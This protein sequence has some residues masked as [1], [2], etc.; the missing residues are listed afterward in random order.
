M[1]YK[2]KTIRRDFDE[3]GDGI[4]VEIRNPLL[5]PEEK[6]QTRKVRTDRDGTVDRDDAYRKTYEL[7][8][9]LIVDWHVLDYDTEDVLDTPTA[10]NV[11]RMP[12]VITTWIGKLVQEAKDPS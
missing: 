11:R 3:L 5:L 1:S 9:E 10:A 4:Y 7:I 2:D 8:A 6:L 12:S